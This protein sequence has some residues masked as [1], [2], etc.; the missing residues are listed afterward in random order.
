MKFPVSKIILLPIGLLVVAV[1]VAGLLHATK[2]KTPPLQVEEQAWVIEAQPIKLETVAPTLPLYGRIETPRTAKLAAALSAEVREVVVREGQVAAKG[3]ILIRLDDRD[4]RLLLASREADVQEAQ[5]AIDSAQRAHDND[6]TAL[7]HEETLL[8]LYDKALQRAKE[9]AAKKLAAQSVVDDAQQAV[10]RQALA[11]ATRRLAVQNFPALLAQ[12]QARLAKAVADRGTA[13]L[14]VKRA[15][16]TAPFAGR[17]AKVSVSP[18]DRVNVG[19]QLLELYDNHALELRAQIPAPH[20]AALR[21][22]LATGGEVQ[23]SGSSDGQ[24]VSVVLER[25]AGQVQQ[26]SGGIDGLFKV[27]A[28]RDTL[29]LG[30]FV[31][32]SLKLAPVSDVA[33]LPATALYGMNRIYL[34]RDGRM[35]GVDVSVVGERSHDGDSQVLVQS[36]KVHDGDRVIVTHLPNAID[37][38]RVKTAAAKP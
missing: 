6:V 2:P 12:L 21:Q 34:L 9:V 16:V 22:A 18:G 35:A 38:L 5:A 26:G 36:P 29:A 11:V 8:Q 37:G 15:R 4:S 19:S 23:G 32:L 20:V 1:I 7:G 33:V 13:A 3:Q 17:I 24:K 28:G 14:N 25:L 31:D 10:E 27:T 30:Q